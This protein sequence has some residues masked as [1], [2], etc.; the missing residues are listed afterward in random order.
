MKTSRPLE[1]FDR[2]GA[3]R[4]VHLNFEVGFG[5]VEVQDAAGGYTRQQWEINDVRLSAE[6]GSPSETIDQVRAACTDFDFWEIDQ[7]ISE[8]YYQIGKR[9]F[10]QVTVPNKIFSGSGYLPF[11]A[12]ADR[13]RSKYFWD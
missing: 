1:A 3:Y 11:S 2:V 6:M 13:R 12:G 9:D 7:R 8:Y 4:L 10:A 5:I